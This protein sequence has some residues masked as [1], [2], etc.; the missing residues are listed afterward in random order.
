MFCLMK[1]LIK[2][3]NHKQFSSLATRND[4]TPLVSLNYKRQYLL[5]SPVRYSNT[6]VNSINDGLR[7]TLTLIPIMHVTG[8]VVCGV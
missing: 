8:V 1:F 7:S 4:G 6:S 2:L 5:H 3:K